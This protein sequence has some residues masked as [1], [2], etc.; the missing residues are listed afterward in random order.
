MSTHEEMGA[1]DRHDPLI[2][3]RLWR[4][5]EGE[6]RSWGLRHVWAPGPNQAVCLARIGREASHRAPGE[7]C[8]CGF[9]A[10]FGPIGCLRLAGDVQAGDAVVL[11]LIRS[12]GE[13]ALH[14]SEGF[15][16]EHASA[17]CLF[18][19]P[20]SV[21]E[22][23]PRWAG[24]G[25]LGVPPPPPRAGTQRADLLRLAAARYAVPL[26]SLRDAAEHGVLEELG[27]DP[28]VMASVEAW[29]G[30]RFE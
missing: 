27:A 15:R 19:D 24:N 26:V 17:A 6:L 3:W 11:G 12:W 23:Y 7:G 30:G 18:T 9:W 16:A 28:G 2:G 21:P 8:S 1:T 4:M 10:L 13:I 14:G 5:G 25:M 20:I 22:T 29:M